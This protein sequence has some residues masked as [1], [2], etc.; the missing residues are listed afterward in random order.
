MVKKLKIGTDCSGIEAPIIALE[1][2]DINFDHVF[3]CD[4]DPLIKE[5]ILHQFEPKYYYDD[6][7]KR[8]NSKLKDI[9]IYFCG[10]PCQSF[11]TAGKRE[12]FEKPNDEGIIFFSC[13]DLIKKKNPKIFVLENVKG[14]ITHEKGET[15][16][17]ILEQLEKLKKYNIFYEV[18]NTCDYNLPQRRERIFIVGIRKDIQK[19][20]FNFPKPM[21]L[22]NNLDDILLDKKKYKKDILTPARKEVV[23]NKKKK[24]NI[25]PNENWIINLNASFPYATTLKDLSPCLITTCNLFYLTK[26]NRFLTTRE[27]M[28]LQG[29]PDD[30]E[31]ITESKNKYYKQVGNSISVNI[32]CYLLIEI[33]KSCDWW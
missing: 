4:N 7:L 16:E 17:I 21:K 27:C 1:E 26:Y 10:F 9:D 33:F 2:L 13:W 23:K 29:F 12:G 32:L 31:L 24:Y 18:L 8:D 11:S 22:T 5:N 15:F 3:S 25:K 6:I 19:K 28:R 20:E 14:L 30:Y